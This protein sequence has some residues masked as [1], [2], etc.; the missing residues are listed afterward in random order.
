MLN[1]IILEGTI[2][3]RNICH[4]QQDKTSGG[5]QECVEIWDS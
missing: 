1:E 3:E 4:R 5:E 2:F